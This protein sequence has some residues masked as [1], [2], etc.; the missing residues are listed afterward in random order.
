MKKCEWVKT[1]DSKLF[2]NEK[3]KV[4]NTMPD[5]NSYHMSVEEFRRQGKELIDWI[6]DYYQNVESFPV[7]SGVKPRRSACRTS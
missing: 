6:A 7:L 1:V 4:G 2:I 5:K 3:S